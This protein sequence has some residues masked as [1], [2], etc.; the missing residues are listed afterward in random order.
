[1]TTQPETVLPREVFDTVLRRTPVDVFVFDTDLICRYAAPVGD[2]FLG[3]PREQ[4]TGR[5][6]AEFWPPAANGLR[7]MLQRAAREAESWQDAGYQFVHQA[8]DQE[9]SCCWSVQIEPV[10]VDG[11]RGVLVSTSDVLK[12]AADRQELERLQAEQQERN[13]ALLEAV[14]DLR[15]LI[16]PLSGYLQLIARRPGTLGLRSPAEVITAVVLPQIRTI[17]ETVDR[18][19]RPPIYQQE[20]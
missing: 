2:S 11:F 20:T 7:P 16:T 3:Q 13:E 1:M 17:L 12:A 10:A 5:P 4:L 9:L 18:L 15:N 6:A 14:S 8:G 19:R